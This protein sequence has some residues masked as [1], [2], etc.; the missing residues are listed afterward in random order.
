MARKEQ[1]L[2]EGATDLISMLPWWAGM[3]C[4]LASFLVL[5]WYTTLQIPSTPE[6]NNFY[7]IAIGDLL[8]GLAIFGQYLLPGVFLAASLLSAVK[9]SKR[10]NL[11]Y[12]ISRSVTQ[13]SLNNLSWR[14]FEFLVGEYFSRRGFR[15]EKTKP[16]IDLI[17]SKDREKYLIQCQQ[18]KIS[19]IGEKIVSELSEIVAGDEATAGFVVTSGEFTKDAIISAKANNIMLLGG[20]ELHNK[21][22]LD[23]SAE[24]Q[25]EKQTTRLLRKVKWT[26][27]LLLIFA[28]CL[29]ALHLEEISTSFHTT[30]SDQIKKIY[31]TNQ[32]HRIPVDTHTDKQINRTES[33]DIKFT[34]IQIRQAIE[35]VVNKKR[36]Q[37]FEIGATDPEGED[38]NSIYEIELIS[39]GWIYTDNAKT[40]EKKITYKSAEGIV[41]SI[42]RVEVKTMKKRKIAD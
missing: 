3:T 17:A 9:N 15:V 16:G 30:L 19:E 6:V 40:T 24:T 10:R 42:D 21:M 29:S 37:Q 33:T 36:R 8:H 41:V 20:R 12:I 25:S 2:L 31:P 5:H 13:E 28:I 4:A 27:A 23:V 7:I 14:D 35:E 34:D 11:Y 32:E 26:L 1:S 38:V 39:G 22:K 18:R